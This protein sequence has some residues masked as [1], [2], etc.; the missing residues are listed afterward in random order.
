M[1]ELI[2]DLDILPTQ[3][4]LA[5][6]GRTKEQ[7]TGKSRKLYIESYGCQM[8]FSDSEI[9][10]AIMQKHGFDTTDSAEKADLILLNTCAI[11][12][13]AEQKIRHRLKELQALKKKR[14]QTTIGVLGCMAERLKSQLLDEEKIVDIV[15]GPDAYRDLPNLVQETD[16]G[17]KAV[18]VFLSREETY[19][20]ISP[21]RLNSNGVSAF[22]S[23][24]R[25]CDNMCSFCVV[26][27]T[28]GR[29]R[30]RNPYSIVQEAREL[31]AQGY[32]EVTLLGQN[33]DSYLWS[34]NPDVI[35]LAGE[36]K[37]IKKGID[38][39]NVEIVNFAQLLE[40]V[41]QISPDLRVRFSTSHPKD[42]TEE[43]LQTMAKYENICKYIHL[44]AQSGNNRIL[45][46]MNRGYTREWYMEKIKTI[47]HYLGKECGIS[48]DIIAGF[49]T[50]TETEHRDT[51]SLM[52]WVQY[53]F[54]YMFYYSERPNTPAAR[55]LKDDVDLETKKRRLQEIINLQRELSLKRNQLD[56]GKIHKVLI[57]GYSKRSEEYLMGRNT[58]NKV[59]IF[60]RK[61]YQKGQYVNVL[62]ESC[63]G[64]TLFG[65]AIE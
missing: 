20:D 65:R 26:P 47:W 54:A 39:S 14:P 4:P 21:V 27:F 23:I 36:K 37:A 59:V 46:L 16:E 18:N 9:V 52:E 29:E 24:M 2:T 49:C 45:E 32:R 31:F 7:N 56:V 25:G 43:V 1:G 13:N 17:H 22:I 8:N 62:V 34:S 61:N 35:S 15:A 6:I 55:R 10:A 30:S 19:A 63:T 44:P 33:V 12:E 5:E 11:R 50:E 28:R 41:A 51:L 53:D 38:L 48:T 64:A 57:E 40:R 42:I 60:P 58:A 3:K